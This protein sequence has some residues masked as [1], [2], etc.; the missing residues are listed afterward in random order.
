MREPGDTVFI[1]L[2]LA[3][4]AGG[5]GEQRDG[6]VRVRDGRI[7]WVGPRAADAALVSAAPPHLLLCV[8]FLAIGAEGRML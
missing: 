8:T 5:Y 3:T 4:M 6:A 1:N 7:T 2:H